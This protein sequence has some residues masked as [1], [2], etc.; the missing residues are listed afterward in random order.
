MMRFT[1][2]PSARVCRTTQRIDA[3]I[4]LPIQRDDA[5]E[6]S[7]RSALPSTRVVDKKTYA[8]R[9]SIL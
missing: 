5:T 8:S 1:G 7:A 4:A 6:H 9:W 2:A 3:I